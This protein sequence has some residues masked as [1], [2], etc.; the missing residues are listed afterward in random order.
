MGVIA[1]WI[2]YKKNLYEEDV[3]MRGISDTFYGD[4]DISVN[5]F[6]CNAAYMVSK[7]STGLSV[8][9]KGESMVYNVNGCKYTIIFDGVIYNKRELI[10]ALVKDG[11]SLKGKADSEILLLAYI[12]WGESCLDK[13]SGKY[14]FAIWSDEDETLFIARDRIG[15]KPLFFYRYD[16]GIVF[17]SEIKNLLAH[18]YIEPQI[19]RLGIASIMLLGPGRAPGDGVFKGIK[20]LKPAHYI[21]L[22]KDGISEREY[23]RLKA[24]EHNHNIALTIEKVNYLITD[25]IKKQISTNLPL[26]TFLSGG[27]DSSIISAV[28]ADSYKQDGRKLT[29]YSVDYV[30]NDVNFKSSEFQ[31]NADTPYAQ[32]MADYINS[33]HRAIL[34]DTPKLI[35]ALGSA[36]YARSLPGMADVDSSL[37]LFCQEV[38][39]EYDIAISGE[40][41]D[42]IFGGYPWFHNKEILFKE[43]FPWSVSTD[44]RKRLVCRGIFKDL[45]ANEYVD[46]YYQKTV[47]KTNYLEGDSPL[48]NRM[49]AMFLLNMKWFMQTLMDRND[50]MSSAAGLDIRTPF[51]DHRIIEY[52]YNIPWNMKSYNDREKGLLRYAF[53]DLLPSDIIWRKKSPYPK[54]HNPNYL[55]SVKTIMNGIIEDKNS[56]ILEFI[57]KGRIRELIETDAK[58]FHKPWYGQLMTGPQVLAYIIQVESWMRK[59]DIQIKL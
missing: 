19:D 24:T 33:D 21:K 7:S 6:K 26:C 31:P 11:G 39:K 5:Q 41:A 34:L 18:P 28:V 49:R 56:R 30:D 8:H 13:L 45:D 2:D 38:K 51:S 12:K 1:G 55:E 47:G 50:R 3:I 32:S 4:A 59:F 35:N 43:G 48:E 23:W 54:T 53:K 40:C 42:E 17:A 57:D 16:N 15:A 22:S 14:A 44:L 36:V 9:A 37:L 58:S 20:E 25:S 46:T 10:K 27:L 52:A 29:T